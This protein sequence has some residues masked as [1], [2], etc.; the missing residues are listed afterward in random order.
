MLP[1]IL[2]FVIARILSGRFAGAGEPGLLIK[3]FVPALFINILL[4][5][6]WVPEYGGN[7][8]AM[9]TN[10]SYTL[11][12]IGML[13]AFSIRTKIPFMEIVR[14]KKSDFRFLKQSLTRFRKR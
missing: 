11:G 6:L 5:L 2:M 8:A 1:G 9:A 3:I 10:I 7:G 12:A 4:N 13:V 14:Y